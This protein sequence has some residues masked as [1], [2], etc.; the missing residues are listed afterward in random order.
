MKRKNLY[1]RILCLSGIVCITCVL[2]F[3][4]CGKKKELKYG[5]I[6]GTATGEI[7]LSKEEAKVEVDNIL[8]PVGSDIDYTSG[9]EVIG[10][11]DDDYSVK[12]NATNVKNDT[13][14]TYTVGYTVDSNGKTYTSNVKVTITDDKSVE[15]GTVAQNVVSSNKGENVGV[16]TG[17]NTSGTTNS[18][19]NQTGNSGSADSGNSSGSQQGSNESQTVPSNQG[20][21]DAGQTAP[22]NPDNNTGSATQATTEKVLIPGKNPATIKNAKLDNAVIEL[23]SGDVVTISCTTKKYIV[24]T[25]TDESIVK[26][27]GHNYSVSKLVVVFNTGAE[28]T[29]ET[30]EKKID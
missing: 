4:G 14:G 7:D 21:S 23:L 6:P 20:G 26:K 8:A 17:Q 15:K 25:R 27:N 13:P 2:G 12:V 16:N 11:E 28:R 18:G 22:A 10:G 29:I 3:A 9:I 24:A 30:I 5:K 19:A 1:R